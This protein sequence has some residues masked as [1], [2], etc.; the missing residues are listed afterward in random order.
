MSINDDRHHVGSKLIYFLKK[1]MYGNRHGLKDKIPGTFKWSDVR[2]LV[3]F[4]NE[5]RTKH[6]FKKE[7]QDERIIPHNKN[8]TC[9]NVNL[10]NY[11]PVIWSGAA[12]VVH[13]IG[14]RTHV[15]R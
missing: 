11:F 9:K 5:L 2:I 12:A 7:F 6:I 10:R 14:L 4:C 3:F 15:S 8:R 13:T 1:E